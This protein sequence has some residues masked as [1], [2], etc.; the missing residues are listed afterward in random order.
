VS[1]ENPREKIRRRY[2]DVRLP[3]ISTVHA[4]LDRHGP[5]TR[6]RRPTDRHVLPR[7]RA[8]HLSPHQSCRSRTGLHL[9]WRD[10]GVRF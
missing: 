10:F 6:G 5:V 2:S 7:H 4:V 1:A 9:L 8:A 3:A